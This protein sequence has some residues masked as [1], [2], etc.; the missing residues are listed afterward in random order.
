MVSR[1]IELPTPEIFIG[2]VAPIGANVQ[3]CVDAVRKSLVSLG[4]RVV[5]LK[6]TDVFHNLKQFIHEKQ[7]LKESPSHDRY[8]SYIAYGNQLR[9]AFNDDAFLAALTVGRLYNV[10]PRLPV[11]ARKYEKQAYLLH[12]FK[13]KEEIDLFRSL[14]GRLFFQISVYSRRGAR[15]DFLAHRFAN[16]ENSGDINRYRAQAEEII[17]IDENE[18]S[19]HGQ[20]V[21][22]AFHDGDFIINADTRVPTI[23][24]QAERFCKLMFGNNSISPTKTEYGMFVAK[25]AAL[26]T[27]DLSRQVGAAVFSSGGEIISIGSNE[28][29]KADGGTYWSD[30][31]FD[32]REFVRGHD[33]NER[34]KREILSEIAEVLE[35]PSSELL[36]NQR[37]RDSQFMDA[38]E[39]GRIIHAEMN[40]ITDAARLGRPMRGGTLLCTAFPCHMC[41]KHIVSAGIAKVIF[42]EPYPKSLVLDLHNDSIVVESSDRGKYADY[43]K[44]EFEHFYGISPRR[45]RELFERGRR[46]DESGNFVEWQFGYPRPNLGVSSPFY[47]D[48]ERELFET[49]VLDYMRV[50]AMDERILALHA[51]RYWDPGADKS[52]PIDVPTFAPLKPAK[53][54]QSSKASKQRPRSSRS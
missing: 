26:R 48:F 25:A 20:K 7:P 33:S 47:N 35:I 40:A 5:E 2:F 52:V 6:V 8:T 30:E 27:L 39:Y 18:A 16:T 49:V 36:Q 34:R 45:Y 10:R 3:G 15:V 42:L 14:Y 46:K 44:V 22:K 54:S 51:I 53:R 32:D 29:P 4:Y 24:Q 9:D 23:Q 21:S 43:P 17:T 28:V 37:V 38:L 12:Q 19:A 1:I 11:D 50:F 31:E 13:R 41:A